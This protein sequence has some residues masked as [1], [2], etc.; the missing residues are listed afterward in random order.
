MSTKIP[1]K[2]A[3]DK[4]KESINSNPSIAVEAQKLDEAI[5]EDFKYIKQI[6]LTPDLLFTTRFHTINSDGSSNLPWD[7]AESIEGHDPFSAIELIP[8]FKEFIKE[9]EDKIKTH[10]ELL[11]PKTFECLGN[12]I[13]DENKRREA[14]NALN[15]LHKEGKKEIEFKT[16]AGITLCTVM[17]NGQFFWHPKINEVMQ[18]EKNWTMED[19][20][21]RFA[22]AAMM[23][24]QDSKAFIRVKNGKVESNGVLADGIFSLNKVGDAN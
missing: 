14:I 15:L 18:D 23:K 21:T 11:F 3:L 22:V 2:D 19:V 4:L 13:Q 1:T 20:P 6:Y 24:G 17:E 12:S 10:P 9:L 5:K 8:S 7:I 16:K